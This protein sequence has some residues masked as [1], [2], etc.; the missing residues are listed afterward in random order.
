MYSIF[1]FDDD[2]SDINIAKKISMCSSIE[3]SQINKYQI[4]QS[5]STM[6]YLIFSFRWTQVKAGSNLP[7]QICTYCLIDLG[8]AYKFRQNC[9]RSD[10]ILQSFVDSTNE[11]GPECTTDEYDE[12]NDLGNESASGSG[13]VVGQES[14]GSM[15][16]YWPPSG[17]NVKLVRNEASRRD[18]LSTSG[19]AAAGRKRQVETNLKVVKS[20]PLDIYD[21]EEQEE[22]LDDTM[23]DNELLVSDDL[24]DNSEN[25]RTPIR[26]EKSKRS[27]DG[28]SVTSSRELTQIK[29][30]K[31][32]KARLGLTA[33]VAKSSTIARKQMRVVKKSD[34]A[35]VVRKSTSSKEQKSLKTCPICGNTYKYQH[36]LESHMRRHRN[37]KPYVCSVCDK[38]FVINFELTRHMRTVSKSRF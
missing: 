31:T 34:G 17:L 37:E 7:E 28:N 12:Q 8:H 27:I 10:A 20:E 26:T 18:P 6:V 4:A 35:D 22:H 16:E 19:G 36:A 29:P 13:I 24:N 15:Y 2:K 21:I 25:E 14:T 11:N 1:D 32:N 9:E 5:R 38:G 3:V 33:L 23:S 30:V